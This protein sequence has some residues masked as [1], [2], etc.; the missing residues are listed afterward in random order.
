MALFDFFKEKSDKLS[1]ILIPKICPTEVPPEI[2]EK[3][4]KLFSD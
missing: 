2:A 3:I 4:D 1:D